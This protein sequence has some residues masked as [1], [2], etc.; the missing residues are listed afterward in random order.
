MRPSSS[1]LSR[2]LPRKSVPK[3]T[4]FAPSLPSI[5]PDRAPT[6]IDKLLQRKAEAI[7]AGK[8]YPQNLRIETFKDE[9]QSWQGV[10]RDVRQELKLLI[11]EK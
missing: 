4:I 6:V 10:S 3:N 2:I 7:Q 8:S 1:S 11:R 5:N 9:K